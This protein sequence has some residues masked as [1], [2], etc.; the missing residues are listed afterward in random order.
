MLYGEKILVSVDGQAGEPGYQT[1]GHRN[2]IG[3]IP[4][5]SMVRTMLISCGKL[6]RDMLVKTDVPPARRHQEP[7][8]GALL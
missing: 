5:L 6:L 2:R 7:M 1:Y 3:L 8:R 4:A